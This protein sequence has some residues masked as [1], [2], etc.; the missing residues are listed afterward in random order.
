MQ[1]PGSDLEDDEEDDVTRVEEGEDLWQTRRDEEAIA[2][3]PAADPAALGEA[4]VGKV[5]MAHLLFPEYS[6]RL[7]FR[8]LMAKMMKL[9]P[10][11]QMLKLLLLGG[12]L[13]RCA[14][15][16]NVSSFCLALPWAPSRCT[17]MIRL[18]LP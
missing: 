8:W 15:V 1:K 11:S 18:L 12:S 13:A 5:S 2:K 14:D 4:E 16:T 10:S 6:F 7:A 9:S 3:A 17:V